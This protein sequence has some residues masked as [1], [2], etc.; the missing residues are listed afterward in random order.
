MLLVDAISEAPYYG[1]GATRT[2]GLLAASAAMLIAFLM[3]ETRTE[4]PLL[5][6]SIFRLRTLAGA[7][8]AALLLGASFFA[9]VFA[10]TLF[11]QEV[12]HYSAL[13]TGAAWLAASITS[14]ALA[15]VS[16]RLVTRIGPMIVMAIG[17]T[18][19][20][21]A[22]IWATQVPVDGHFLANLAG[23]FVLAGAGTAFS[24]IPISV[25]ALQGVAEKQSGL[26]SGLLN[27]STSRRAPRTSGENRP[28]GPS[29][30][31][32]R[33]AAQKRVTR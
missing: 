21:G 13:Q 22:I 33:I 23:P 1:W 12:L 26:A 16:Q 10:G 3:I 29:V 8:G 19:I 32:R 6:L 24:F 20:G 28:S 14:M 5:P 15:A 31:C 17:M 18:M 30:P 9:F 11:M 27:T 7:N 25:A 2:I 4:D